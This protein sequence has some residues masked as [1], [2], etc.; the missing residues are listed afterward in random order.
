MDFSY[1]EIQFKRET[2]KKGRGSEDLFC[3]AHFIET[4]LQKGIH[5]NI[6]PYAR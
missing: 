1:A 5:S 3:L 4:H 6:A 2:E